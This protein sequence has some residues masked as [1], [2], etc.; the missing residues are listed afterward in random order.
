MQQVEI[1]WKKLSSGAGDTESDERNAAVGSRCDGAARA[2]HPG[3]P[4]QAPRRLRIQNLR[5]RQELRP[6]VQ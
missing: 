2:R 4:L 5:F 3:L 6:S 1:Q